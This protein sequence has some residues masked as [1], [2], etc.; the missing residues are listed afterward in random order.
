MG[1]FGNSTADLAMYNVRSIRDELEQINE[2]LWKLENPQKYI[3]GDQVFLDGNLECVVLAHEVK[4]HAAMWGIDHYHAYN[5]L[6][7]KHIT[8][9]VD[10]KELETWRDVEDRAAKQ[11]DEK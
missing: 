9:W 11:N 2:R 1:L 10:E 3:V 4:W 8:R 7:N 5:V 6:Y